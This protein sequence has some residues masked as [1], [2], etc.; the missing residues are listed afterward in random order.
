MNVL[1]VVVGVILMT[2]AAGICWF[3]IRIKY[4]PDPIGGPMYLIMTGAMVAGTFMLLK[5]LE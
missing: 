4:V 5:G 2:V 1:L 3:Q